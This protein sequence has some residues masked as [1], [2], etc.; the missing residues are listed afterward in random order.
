MDELPLLRTLDGGAPDFSSLPLVLEDLERR[1]FNLLAGLLVDRVRFDGALAGLPRADADLHAQYPRRC[2]VTSSLALAQKT[3]AY[4][5]A[6]EG[7]VAWRH[8][9]GG[10]HASQFKN[11]KNA[12]DRAAAL[13]CRVPAA[14]LEISH[15]KW[16]G[17]VDRYM[18]NRIVSSDRDGDEARAE[19]VTQ[20]DRRPRATRV[21]SESFRFEF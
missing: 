16:W 1:G 6:G 10:H 7:A 19:Q 13:A 18:A 4:L 12:S 20:S 11:H 17:D 8:K 5:A 21:D 3:V 14:W 15:F 2:N 9:K